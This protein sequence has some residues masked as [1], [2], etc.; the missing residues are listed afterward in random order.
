MLRLL[1]V[2]LALLV[3]ATFAPIAQATNYP[4]RAIQVVVPWLP[5]GSSDISARIINEKMREVLGQPFVVANIDG[6]A[7]LNGAQHVHRARP[8]GYTLLWEHAGNLTVAPMLTGADFRWTDF[9]LV[10][11]VAYTDIAMIGT[12]QLPLE[13]RSGRNKGNKGH[14]WKSTLGSG[15]ERCIAPHIS[16]HCGFRGRA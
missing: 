1:T 15:A 4:T 9:E 2:T 3:F 10:C 11:A 13:Q 16:Q 6:A 12:G 8:D 14:S 7:G 5:G